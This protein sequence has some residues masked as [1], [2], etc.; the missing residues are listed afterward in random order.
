[1]NP[2]GVLSG[3]NAFH[4]LGCFGTSHLRCFDRPHESLTGNPSGRA[5]DLTAAGLW[6]QVDERTGRTACWFKIT[7]REGVYEGTIVKV[8]P[9]AGDSRMSHEGETAEKKAAGFLG[10]TL[11][12]GDAA[13]RK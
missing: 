7:E 13:G 4:H 5:T 12:Q 11:I 2:R 8:F 10:L 3:K 6:K 1:L 9:E